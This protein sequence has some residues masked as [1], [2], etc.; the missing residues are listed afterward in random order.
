M[1]LKRVGWAA[2][3]LIA[4]SVTPAAAIVMEGSPKNGLSSTALRRNALTTNRESL[5]S[6]MEHPIKLA[7]GDTLFSDDLDTRMQLH[8]PRARAVMEEIVKCALAP[9]A[10]V[11]YEDPS[12]GNQKYTWGGELGLCDPKVVDPGNRSQSVWGPDGPNLM[13]KQLVT[14]CVVARVNALGKAIPLSLR[15]PSSTLFPAHDTV[16][17]EKRFRESRPGE[18][19]AEGTFLVSFA[20]P[21]CLQGHDCRWQPA[22]VGQCSG[23]TISLAIEDPAVCGST[24]VRVCAGIHG[25]YVPNTVDKPPPDFPPLPQDQYMKYLVEKRGAC[26]GSPISFPCPTALPIGGF[27]SVMTQ[28]AQPSGGGIQPVHPPSPTLIKTAGPGVYPASDHEVFGFR[29]GAFYGNLF[30]PDQLLWNCVIDVAEVRICTPSAGVQGA[31]EKCSLRTEAAAGISGASACAETRTV[32]YPDVYA[33]YSLAQQQDRPD[34]DDDAL[35][36][37]VLNERICD[38]PSPQTTCFFHKP[39]RCHFADPAQNASSGS[40][41]DWLAS[42]GVYQNCK[43]LNGDPVISYPPITTY[44]NDP[45]DLL[46]HGGLCNRV[47]RSLASSPAAPVGAVVRPGCAGCSVERGDGL[48]TFSSAVVLGYLMITRRRRRAD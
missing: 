17:T 18:D 25:C 39:R 33:C 34:T 13:C 44:L 6:L 24:P 48:Q 1:R 3:A 41:C 15:G 2:V 11:S 31:V 19:P 47:R 28:P 36:V 30:E 16:P 12:D 37:A 5:Q 45:C 43:S 4:L 32:P 46:G 23:G 42:A 35:G 8:D 14:A 22:F 27:Y 20:G 29:E 26:V 10:T 40:H 38:E 7:P 21:L 9:P